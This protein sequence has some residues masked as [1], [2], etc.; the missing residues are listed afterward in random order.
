MKRQNSKQAAGSKQEAKGKGN[1]TATQKKARGGKP[2]GV[3]PAAANKTAEA[4]VEL[5]IDAK[6]IH[7]LTAGA[8]PAAKATKD[9]APKPKQAETVAEPPDDA[10]EL[11]VFAFRLSRAER[12][13]IHAAAGSAKASKFVRTLAVAAARGDGPAVLGILDSIQAKQ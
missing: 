7:S 1:Q 8:R 9:T 12:D 11:V 5:L 10:E 6:G 3:Q 13:L 2:A 4:T